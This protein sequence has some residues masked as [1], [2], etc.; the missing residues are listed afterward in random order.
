L[1]L[2]LLAAVVVRVP[3][4]LTASDD[5]SALPDQAE[6]VALADSLLGGEGLRFVDSRFADEVRSYRMPGYPLLVALCGGSVEVVRW[7]QMLIDASTVTAIVLL[8]RQLGLGRFA[9]VGGGFVAFSPFLAYFTGLVLTETLFTALLAWGAALLAGVGAT[10]R[11][12]WWLGLFLLIAAIFVKPSAIVLPTLLGGF[13]VLLHQRHPFT[14]ARRWPLPPLATCAL[15][16]V[17]ALLPWAVRNKLVVDAWIWTT[18]NGGVTLY[19]GLNGD[20]DGSSDQTVLNMLPQLRRMTEVQRAAYLKDRAF[21][22]AEQHPW[23]VAELAIE[24]LRRTWSPVPLDEANQSVPRIVAGLLYSVPLWGLAIVGIAGGKLRRR[25]VVFLLLPALYF[26]LGHALTV[27]SLRYR[28]PIEPLLSVLA[29]AGVA[30]LWEL[31]RP[32]ADKLI[33]DADVERIDRP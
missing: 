18:T 12:M 29:A 10:R 28:V 7:V 14:A 32:R 30:A 31:W 4:V 11:V 5:L 15:L 3:F 20:A 19:D 22:F 21:D 1:W 17:I 23:R 27:G 2:L 24:K 8:G 26:T 16:T 13:S 9:L 33:S 6:Y 25:E